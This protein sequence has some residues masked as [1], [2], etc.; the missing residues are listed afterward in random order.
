MLILKSFHRARCA[1][2]LAA[3]IKACKM[4]NLE[5]TATVVQRTMFVGLASWKLLVC[6]DSTLGSVQA[7]SFFFSFLGT[8]NEI[9]AGFMDS[10]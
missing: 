7:I 6:M 10:M 3:G 1:L 4:Q 5:L 8:C 9:H 2:D